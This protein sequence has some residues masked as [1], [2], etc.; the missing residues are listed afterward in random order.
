MIRIAM[1]GN[2]IA[3]NHHIKRF[4]S[5][6][7]VEIAAIVNPDTQSVNDYCEK[8]HIAAWYTSIND[9]LVHEKI[10]ALVCASPDNTHYDYCKQSIEHNLA[11]FCEKPVAQYSS[12]ILDL[13]NAAKKANVLAL[14]NF[15][16]RNA[17]ALHLLK[18][19][20][21]ENFAGDILSVHSEYNQNW[22]RT[23]CWGDWEREGSWHW[24]LKPSKGTG[25]IVGDLLTH[26]LDSLRFLCDDI[27][28]LRLESS[29]TFFEGIKA[30]L[31][32]K[33]QNVDSYAE[34]INDPCPV[35]IDTKISG[36]GVYKF[37]GN[38]PAKNTTFPCTIHTS[39]IADAQE[40]FVIEITGTKAI[41]TLDLSKSRKQIFAV[42]ND[43][44]EKIFTQDSVPA[45][46]DIFVDAVKNR[47][48]VIPDFF[49]AYCVQKLIE[50]V[51]PFKNRQ[52]INDGI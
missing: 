27:R 25:G 42:F 3:A 24:R 46:Y 33:P 38:S 43:K 19:L 50:T 31:V 16:K 26:Q 11:L 15:S 47:T 6:S 1:I 41:L 48:A 10:D 36:Q 12:D 14:I 35:Y 9:L 34:Q 2:G 23:K 20:I 37:L 44:T 29:T 21:S 4:S 13:Q 7:D 18:R 8:K 49:D 28:S 5:I 40:Q 45:L 32:P 39:W 17:P 22:L 30:D 52:I 51:F